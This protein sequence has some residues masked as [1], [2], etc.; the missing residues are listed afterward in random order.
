MRCNKQIGDVIT[1]NDD[2][3]NCVIVPATIGHTTNALSRQGLT[4]T[5][6]GLAARF[7]SYPIF[8]WCVS[9]SPQNMYKVKADQVMVVMLCHSAHIYV[10]LHLGVHKWLRPFTW[11]HKSH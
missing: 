4:R 7:P 9:Q 2:S 5:N 8:I 1:S 10:L 3:L 11:D 6:Y